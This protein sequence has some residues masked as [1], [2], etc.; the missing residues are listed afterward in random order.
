MRPK[1]LYSCKPEQTGTEEFGNMLKRI[2]TLE[3]RVPAE[4]A[5]NWRIEVKKKR[6]TRKESQRVVN[7]FEI[8]GFMAQKKAFGNSLEEMYFRIEESGL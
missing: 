2:Q 4:E 7:Q 8:E 6:I 1:L 3:G 5:T